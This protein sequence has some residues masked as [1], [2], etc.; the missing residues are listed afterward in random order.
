M[1]DSP[2]TAKIA[3]AAATYWV[4]R[5]FDYRIPPALADK[6]VPGVRVVVPFGGGN[7]RTEGIV[8][9]LGTA[10]SGMRLKSIASVLDVA[11]AL[12]GDDPLGGLAA[13]AVFLHGIRCRTCD[14]ARRT[15]VPDGVGIY[16]LRRF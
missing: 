16:A 10:Q 2:A 4:D 3:V 15:L 1:T 9:S 7:R 8:L 14:A 13:R 12:S 6:V 11:R 5:P